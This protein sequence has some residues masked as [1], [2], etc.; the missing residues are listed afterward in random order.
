MSP[1]RKPSR[2]LRRIVMRPASRAPAPVVWACWAAPTPARCVGTAAG[3]FLNERAGTTRAAGRA[4]EPAS[5]A[6][7]IHRVGRSV[8]C[9]TASCI[10]TFGAPM[11]TPGAG[12]ARPCAMW[13]G[14]PVIF[15][16]RALALSPACWPFLGKP[17]GPRCPLPVCP[18][19]G[20]VRNFCPKLSIRPA[21]QVCRM[22]KPEP[23]IA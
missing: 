4:T 22:A 17:Q 14:E 15:A 10:S 16:M 21:I 19:G 2:A 20:P 13:R 7:K 23:L 12:E 5:V 18:W 8:C 3:G 9:L 1:Q 11:K 6:G